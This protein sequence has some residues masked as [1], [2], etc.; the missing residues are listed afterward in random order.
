MRKPYLHFF[1]PLFFVLYYLGCI[2][3]QSALFIKSPWSYFQSD[4]LVIFVL[5][6][7][8]RRNFTEGGVLSLVIG[9]L[10][11]SHSSVPKG[12]FALAAILLFLSIRTFN[13]Y[14]VISQWSALL[15]LT[16]TFSFVFK[17]IHFLILIFIHLSSRHWEYAL[18]Y[19]PLPIV[20]NGF[21]GFYLYKT[22]DRLD[23]FTT[24]ELNEDSRQLMDDE[25]LVSDGGAT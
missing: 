22:F 10:T 8:L 23:R 11:E 15:T 17:C 5:W 6:F 12:T 24:K 14:F 19:L 18:Y 3:V 21:I 9:Y 25:L 4:L 1:N 16:L 20:M 2:F 7:A 13:Y